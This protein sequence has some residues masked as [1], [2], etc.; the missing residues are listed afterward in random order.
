M[1]RHE[2][3][4][5]N[6]TFIFRGGS[7]NLRKDQLDIDRVQEQPASLICAECQ[8]IPIGSKVIECRKVARSASAHVNA[9]GK[10]HAT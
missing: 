10:W 2:A 1:V 8:G 6:V 7:H 4:R 5:K 3:V 9:P